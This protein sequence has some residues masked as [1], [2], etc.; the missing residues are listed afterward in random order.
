MILKIKLLDQDN[1]ILDMI[2][3]IIHKYKED[4]KL[5]SILIVLKQGIRKEMK[6]Q[7][8]GEVEFSKKK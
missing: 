8:K 3:E 2:Q 4:L 6:F 7:L 5:S 1:I